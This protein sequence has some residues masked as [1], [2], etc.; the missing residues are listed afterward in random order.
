MKKYLS[1]ALIGVISAM[2]SGCNSMSVTEDELNQ[3]VEKRLSTS[4]PDVINLT[5]NQSTLNLDLLVKQADIDLSDKNGG[6]V[7][8]AMQTDMRG[9]LSMF[10]QTLS[11]KTQLSPSF[12]SGLRIEEDR[13][14]LVGPKLT[15][16]TVQGSS[17]NDQMLR[18]TLGSLHTEFES[19]LA[20]YFDEHPVYVLNHSASE[21]AAAK[22]VK[23]IVITNDSIEFMLF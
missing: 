1:V 17:I 11:M 12:E 10:G 13:V 8:V 19:A 16:V 23:N 22:L 20:H 4:Q 2:L 7:A 6:V 14:Y 9:T 21:K 18:N 15:Q 3:E 5:L